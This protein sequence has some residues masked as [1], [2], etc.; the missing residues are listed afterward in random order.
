MQR[1]VIN[2]RQGQSVVAA[3]EERARP[4]GIRA[5]STTTETHKQRRAFRPANSADHFRNHNIIV[6]DVSI[7][8]VPVLPFVEELPNMTMSS[9]EPAVGGAARVFPAMLVDELSCH[10][11][12]QQSAVVS[13]HVFACW[14]Q[15]ILP[16]TAHIAKVALIRIC[17]VGAVL[18]L[19][20]LVPKEPTGLGGKVQ[21]RG[22]VLFI[23]GP[24]EVF[25][26]WHDVGEIPRC[27]RFRGCLELCHALLGI[28]KPG[29]ITHQ[30]CFER[31]KGLPGGLVDR[32]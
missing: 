21:H 16:G 24:H 9:V 3:V 1:N 27:A 19:V 11:V 6:V 18:G 22:M 13:G 15:Q 8:R 14:I 12:R 10:Q 20:L 29:H 31:C 28:R 26:H 23:D 2:G 5:P 7:K 17:G 30:I 4:A 32:I 25:Q